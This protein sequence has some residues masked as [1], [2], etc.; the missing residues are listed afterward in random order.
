MTKKEFVNVGF[1][2]HYR[3]V[4][5]GEL[6]I[7]DVGRQVT[8]AGWVNR[9]RDHGGLIF[10][11]LRDSTGLVQVVVTPQV[12]DAAHAAASEVRGEY[13]IQVKGSVALR[14][15]GTENTDMPTGAI[16]VT[17]EDVTILNAAKTPP[18]YINEDSPVD[19]QLRLRYRYLDLR[20]ERMHNN[21]VMR[22][23]VVQ[24]IRTFLRDR[25]FIEIE[26]PV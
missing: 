15:A 23:A 12:S 11:D 2:V 20:R 26:T 14:R 24:Y 9:R 22:D 13:V 3:S 19:E 18:F 6:T 8:L 7:D 4:T 1:A 16:E 25:G 21:I 17:A 5:C 10:L